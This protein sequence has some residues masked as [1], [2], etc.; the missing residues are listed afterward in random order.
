V[1]FAAV[2]IFTHKTIGAAIGPILGGTL[3]QALG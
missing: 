1:L 2:M 3:V